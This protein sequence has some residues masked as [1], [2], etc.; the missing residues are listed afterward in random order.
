MRELIKMVVILTILSSFSGGILA[1][2]KD[3]TEKDIDMQRLK[4]E[5]APAIKEIL[6]NATNDPLKD[7]FVVMDGKKKVSVFVGKVDEKFNF[8]TFEAQGKGFGGDMGVMIGVNLEED[9]IIGIGV[10]T[11]SE[12]PGIG[13]KAKT[14][15]AFKAQFVDMALVEKFSVKDDGGAVD[16][17]SGA[18][19]TSKGVCIALNQA[20]ALYKRIKPEI[21]KK[22]N[23]LPK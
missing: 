16:T 4:F 22:I 21:L 19:V 5:K 3:V 15:K 7:R 10:T 1:Y 20:S 11:H 12:T 14:D 17:I 23:E 9:K 13:S 2:V 8:I 18:T 6:A